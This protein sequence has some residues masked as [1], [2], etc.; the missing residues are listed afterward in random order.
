M[1]PQLRQYVRKPRRHPAVGR[2]RPSQ[3]RWREAANRLLGHGTGPPPGGRPA[4][5]HLHHQ[6]RRRRHTRRSASA[7]PRETC[8]HAD[9]LRAAAVA[10]ATSK[11]HA[12]HPRHPLASGRE[13]PGRRRADR[14]LRLGDLPPVLHRHG[15]G[16]EA[17]LSQRPALLRVPNLAESVRDGRRRLGQPLREVQRS[18]PT[19]FSN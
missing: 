18:L 8:R 13:R 11:T 15:G 5:S 3:P 1:D 9:D 10:R 12:R 6:R 4:D 19:A 17:G 14:R 7:E 16:M 2:S